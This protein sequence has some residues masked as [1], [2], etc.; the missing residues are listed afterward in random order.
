MVKIEDLKI[1][2]K[3]YDYESACKIFKSL[4]SYK[5]LTEEEKKKQIY[6]FK[7]YLIELDFN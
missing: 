6:H 7:I 1:E 5:Y 2:L 4:P 3:P